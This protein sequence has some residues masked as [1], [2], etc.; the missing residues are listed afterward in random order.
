MNGA[1]VI[2]TNIPKVA[3]GHAPQADLICVK[4][5]KSKLQTIREQGVLVVVDYGMEILKEYRNNLS[6][7]G[8]PGIGDEFMKWLWDNIGVES[9]CELVTIHP[10]PER[11]YEE[12]P[13]DPDLT[14]FDKSDRK[15]VAVAVASKY[16]PKILNA[17]DSDWWE[18]Y[19][20][21]S[22]FVS[23]EFV[24]GELPEWSR[25]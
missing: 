22:K 15:F 5:C 9:V 25:P 16:E 12:F 4:S 8:E 19:D 6:Q 10:N 3:N 24:C 21:L 7:S 18:C 1:V 13:D 11:V 2:D 17:V 14:N 20:A 23:I